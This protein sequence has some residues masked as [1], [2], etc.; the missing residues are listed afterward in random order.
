[1][2][3]RDSWLEH[4]ERM[5]AMTL[6]SEPTRSI[7]ARIRARGPITLPDHPGEKTISFIEVNGKKYKVAVEME[8]Q[9]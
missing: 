4:I 5:W 3:F 9:Q 7:V 6:G 2:S 8:G 1:M